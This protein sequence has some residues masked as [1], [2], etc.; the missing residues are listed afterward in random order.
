MTDEET[1]ALVA[2]I[3]GLS[4]DA[5]YLASS[6]WFGRVL[7]GKPVLAAAQNER[8]QAAFD[9]LLEVGFVH[10]DVERGVYGYRSTHRGREA[11]PFCLAA[12]NGPAK[13]D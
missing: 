8:Q 10:G 6:D 5:V 1:R 11:S 12:I 3:N 13:E 9:E 4:T 2:D 7:M